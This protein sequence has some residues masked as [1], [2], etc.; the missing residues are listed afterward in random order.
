LSKSTDT[1]EF[2][3]SK[4]TEFSGNKKVNEGTY[5]LKGDQLTMKIN[6]T[7]MT[8]TLA[9]DKKSFVVDSADGLADLAKGF[10]YTKS[11]D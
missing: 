7:N 5:Q 3:G 10:K 4:V 1:L 9:K 11:A 2:K 8:A 6:E